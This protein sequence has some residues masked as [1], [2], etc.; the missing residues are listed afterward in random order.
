MRLIFF[1]VLTLLFRPTWAQTC[2]SVTISGPISDAPASWL[3]DDQLVGAGVE[4]ARTTLKAAGVKEVKVRRFSTWAETLHATRT[5]EI[6]MIISAGWSAERAR[7]L[8]YVYPSYAYQF[9]YVVVRKGQQ[10][11]LNEYADLKHRK[12][13]TGAGVTFGDSSFGV[14]VEKELNLARS[15]NL[16]ESFRRLLDGEVDYILAYEDSASSEIYRRDLS[17]KVRVLATYPYRI[18]TF[19]AFSKRSK[20]G[21]IWKDKLGAEIEKA[22]KQNQY[23]HLLNKY[24]SV[25]NE[26]QPLPTPLPTSTPAPTSTPTSTPTPPAK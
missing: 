14:F 23:F 1:I 4:L 25:F 21:S 19:F 3:L 7:F 22:S 6:D 17:D 13:V 9:L 20:C 11:R 5:G 24:R 2:D 26:S 8:T 12:G 18:D 15:P 16:G 10:F